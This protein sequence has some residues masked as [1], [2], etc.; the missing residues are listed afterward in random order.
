MSKIRNGRRDSDSR[1]RRPCTSQLNKHFRG[2]RCMRCTVRPAPLTRSPGA[3]CV[4]A[5]RLPAMTADAPSASALTMC[6]LFWMPPSAMTGTPKQFASLQGR[7]GGARGVVEAWRQTLWQCQMRGGLSQAPHHILFP[8]S[9]LSHYSN[10]GKK[11][12]HG[13]HFPSRRPPTWMCG[14]PRWPA[15]APPRR[16]PAW[17]RWS[18]Y[19]Y[20][21]AARPPPPRSAAAP[22]EREQQA[23]QRRAASAK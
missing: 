20:P 22:A 12:P 9:S 1:R 19:P 4:P 15:P 23:A 16:P 18:R 17:C 5:N 14:T 13:A 2:A 3:S 8:T 7:R 6:P 21:R 10:N 11:K